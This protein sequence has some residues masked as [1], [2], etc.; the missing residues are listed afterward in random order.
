M[1]SGDELDEGQTAFIIETAG[2]ITNNEA[3]TLARKMK[4]APELL[5]ALKMCRTALADWD[6]DTEYSDEWNK[7]SAAIAKAEQG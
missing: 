2:D 5:E 1:L 3:R 4:A 6:G 7:M